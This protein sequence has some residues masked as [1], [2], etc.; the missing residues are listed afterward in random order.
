MKILRPRTTTRTRTPLVLR[1]L[2]VE[3]NYISSWIGIAW[4]IV[5]YLKWSPSPHIYRGEPPSPR[6]WIQQRTPGTDFSIQWGAAT[7][8]IWGGG[9][10]GQVGRPPNGIWLVFVPTRFLLWWPFYPCVATS[11]RLVFAPRYKG[12]DC[13]PFSI[14]S[15]THRNLEGHVEFGNLLVAWV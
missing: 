10:H 13:P 6:P 1:P 14:K 11:D 5:W 2:Q 8:K 12:C 4:M 9:A 15:C 3:M 7:S